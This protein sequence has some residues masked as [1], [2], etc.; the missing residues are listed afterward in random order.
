MGEFLDRL[1]GKPKRKQ[2]S[3]TINGQ[4]K[5]EE[6]TSSNPKTTILSDLQDSGS[7][8]YREIAERTHIPENVVRMK[9]ESMIKD[10]WIQYSQGNE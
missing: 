8:T 9:C 6:S 1:T 3:I 7:S 10:G 2:V 5:C 4:R